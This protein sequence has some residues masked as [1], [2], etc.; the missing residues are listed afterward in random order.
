M[1][2]F[3][4]SLIFF[5]INFLVFVIYREKISKQLNIT[6]QYTKSEFIGILFLLILLS[7]LWPFEIIVTI[8]FLLFNY[9]K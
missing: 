4:I 6:L 5:C 3:I 1:N 2:Y 7:L 8:I 9:K